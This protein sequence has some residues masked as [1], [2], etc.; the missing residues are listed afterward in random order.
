MAHMQENASD[1]NSLRTIYF[2]C[3]HHG[4]DVHKD[5]KPAQRVDGR[6][7]MDHIHQLRL[8]AFQLEESDGITTRIVCLGDMSNKDSADAWNALSAVQ[9]I[10]HGL[11]GNHDA[12]N[13]PRSEIEIATNS[14]AY[15]HAHQMGRI[16]EVRLNPFYNQEVLLVPGANLLIDSFGIERDWADT[17]KNTAKIIRNY[18]PT[19]HAEALYGWFKEKVEVDKYSKKGKPETK[20]RKSMLDAWIAVAHNKPESKM[21]FETG[22]ETGDAVIRTERIRAPK[23]LTCKLP[24]GSCLGGNIQTDDKGH[25]QMVHM[26]VVLSQISKIMGKDKA[27][28]REIYGDEHPPHFKYKDNHVILPAWSAAQAGEVAQG[29]CLETVYHKGAFELIETSLPFDPEVA[30]AAKKFMDAQISFPEIAAA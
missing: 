23:I 20:P 6:S 19:E 3:A 16:A 30:A 4:E 22:N 17:Y 18:I 7:A 25:F 26:D 29:H 21:K 27:C 12:Y 10:D 8:H 14:S 13:F 11:V 15:S 24:D 2:T 9:H 1:C 28:L 5:D